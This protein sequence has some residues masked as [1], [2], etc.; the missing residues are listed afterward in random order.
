MTTVTR[1]VAVAVVSGAVVW[2]LWALGGDPPSRQDVGAYT[3]ADVRPEEAQALEV[4][5]GETRVRLSRQSTRVWRG[6]TGTPAASASMMTESEDALLPLRAYRRLSISSSDPSVGLVKPEFVV[7][8]RDRSGREATV[9]VGAPNFLGAG[10]YATG[11]GDPRVYL[12]SR[13]T[14][15]ALRSL[16][17]GERFHSPRPAK[18]TAVFDDLARDPGDA[19]EP[20]LRQALDEDKAP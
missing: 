16:A 11:S 12:V 19:P 9:S 5:S 14:V 6:D 4:T 10:F 17:A 1:L 7:V 8:V 20:W 2:G 3:L 18:E 15:D 13:G